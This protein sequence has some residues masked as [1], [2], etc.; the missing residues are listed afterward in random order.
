MEETVD[1][2][3]EVVEIC[4]H[5]L[6]C[7]R[8]IYPRETFERRIIF[9]TPVYMSRHPEVCRYCATV[10]ANSKKM[11]ENGCCDRIVCCI[12]NMEGLAIESYVFEVS[13]LG[14]SKTESAKDEDYLLL[15][16]ETQLRDLIFRCIC[17]EWLLPTLAIECRFVLLVH[18]RESG[19]DTQ[20]INRALEAG[21]WLLASPRESEVF[22]KSGLIS[23]LRSVVSP[24]L[25]FQLYAVH[26][27]KTS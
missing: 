17:L 9:G 18:T 4:L 24:G 21:S 6:L 3:I 2:F 27:G 19:F 15:E 23:P 13:R 1:L 20:H 5:I 14:S 12:T 16:T 22:L 7:V 26:P 8:G 25:H 10:L 11:L